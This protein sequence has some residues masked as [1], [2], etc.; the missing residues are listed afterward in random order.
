[1]A[2]TSGE[3][4]ISSGLRIFFSEDF[5]SSTPISRIS[6]ATAR[7][8]MYS[9]RPWPKGCSGSGLRPASRKPSSVTKDEPASDRLLKASAV[10]AMEPLMVPANSFPTNSSRFSPMPTAPQSWP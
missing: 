5:P 9:M 7:P 4:T 2:S 3:D 6:P 8:E 1:M 10:M